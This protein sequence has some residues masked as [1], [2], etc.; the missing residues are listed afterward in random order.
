MI[1]PLNQR[2]ANNEFVYELSD[3]DT[4]K[5]FFTQLRS[6]CTAALIAITFINSH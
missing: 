2:L 5:P 6:S 4:D 1:R 3:E